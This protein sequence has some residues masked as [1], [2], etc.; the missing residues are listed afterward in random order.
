MKKERQASI[1]MR[2]ASIIMCIFARYKIYFFL[3]GFRVT[4]S[5]RF[6]NRSV[7]SVC[8]YRRS[9]KV[10]EDFASGSR[11]RTKF[12]YYQNLCKSKQE[13]RVSGSAFEYQLPAINYCRKTLYH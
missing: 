8:I 11:N 4:T 6:A 9:L 10:N 12:F 7:F 3:S 13:A 5:I 1:I 2:E